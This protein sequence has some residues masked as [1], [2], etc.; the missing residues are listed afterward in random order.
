MTD[1]YSRVER[2][3]RKILEIGEDI[4][5]MKIEVINQI[6]D[7]LDATLKGK[8]EKYVSKRFKRIEKKLKKLEEK[9]NKK[10]FKFF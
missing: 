6:L 5:F 10:R 2:L 3:E 9:L 1:L 4:E 8:D 7:M